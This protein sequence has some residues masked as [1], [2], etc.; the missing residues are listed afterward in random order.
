MEQELEHLEQRVNRLLESARRLADE[1]RQLREQLEESR[2]L[3]AALQQRID[4]ARSTVQNALSRLP[5]ATP[6]G[7]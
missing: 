5:D 2:V 6:E 4:E 7:A 3:Q 1:N